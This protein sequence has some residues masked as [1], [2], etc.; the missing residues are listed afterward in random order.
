M[1]KEH[2]TNKFRPKRGN[3]LDDSKTRTIAQRKANFKET[4]AKQTVSEM[5]TVR[6]QRNG[7][8]KAERPAASLSRGRKK[9]E[10]FHQA[11]SRVLDASGEKR[12]RNPEQLPKQA[13]A[14]EKKLR[15]LLKLNVAIKELRA[16]L[17]NGAQLDE[18]QLAKLER[19]DAVLLQLDEVLTA[20]PRA[21]ER[22]AQFAAMQQEL[23]DADATEPAHADHD[24]RKV[25]SDH[26]KVQFAAATP[27]DDKDECPEL[28]PSPS[29]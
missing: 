20:Y 2:R 13:P 26:K 15:Q 12:R 3:V 27:A 14:W 7:A 23:A 22:F 29:T 10:T 18:Q 4:H 1:G 24:A 25:R 8:G 11:H 17:E 19:E 28:V 6:K 5:R 9:C 21:A 16:R